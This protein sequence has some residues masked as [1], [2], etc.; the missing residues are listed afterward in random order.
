M[1][2]LPVYVGT[3]TD[4]GDIVETANK[5]QV[6]VDEQFLNRQK[7]SLYEATVYFSKLIVSI[8]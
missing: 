4:P 7:T 8:S 3:T 2:H 6:M 5:K 1:I